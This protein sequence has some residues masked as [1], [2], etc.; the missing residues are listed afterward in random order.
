MRLS[1]I[2]TVIKDCHQHFF[3]KEH[4]LQGY[5]IMQISAIRRLPLS[6]FLYVSSISNTL[7]LQHT[8]S[9]N[10][11]GEKNYFKYWQKWK[12]EVCTQ[13]KQI[14]KSSVVDLGLFR[15]SSSS[16]GSTFGEKQSGPEVIKRS[17]S[18]QLSMNLILLINVKMPRAEK[19]IYY[20]YLS[21]K[22][23]MPYFFFFIMS[24]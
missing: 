12:N 19:I 13:Q 5:Y 14:Q 6:V 17:C 2:R 3:Y 7:I 20:A 22:S 9:L 11:C 23:W 24:L 1:E 15:F 4:S 18:T 16:T 21:L 8:A 10:L